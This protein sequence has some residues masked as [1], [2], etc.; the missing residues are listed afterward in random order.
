MS[1]NKKY[2]ASEEAQIENPP[3]HLFNSLYLINVDKSSEIQQHEKREVFHL[4]IIS[5]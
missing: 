2:F 4:F 3:T 5:K 1:C